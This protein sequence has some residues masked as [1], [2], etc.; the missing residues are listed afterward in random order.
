[1]PRPVEIHVFPDVYPFNQCVEQVSTINGLACT[2]H[3]YGVFVLVPLNVIYL[4][5]GY[6]S[7]AAKLLVQE[8][9]PLV[10]N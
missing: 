4:F 5:P 2:K 8:R 3:G 6:D 10:W 7:W 1:M 9:D